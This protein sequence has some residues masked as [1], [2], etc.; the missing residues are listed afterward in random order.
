MRPRRALRPELADWR[1]PC[2]Y[3]IGIISN[4]DGDFL[5][6]IILHIHQITVDR[7]VV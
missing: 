3:T 5:L 6:S 2:R 1:P 7:V 4:Y